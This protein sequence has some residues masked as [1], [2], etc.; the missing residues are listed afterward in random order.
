MQLAKKLTAAGL[1][2]AGGIPADAT[3]GTARM[4]EICSALDA[5][6]LYG[7][8]EDLDCGGWGGG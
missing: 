1:P 3:I 4:N 5:R 8:P 2:F 6:L 7:Q